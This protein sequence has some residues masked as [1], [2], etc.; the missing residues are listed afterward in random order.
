MMRIR[1][2]TELCSYDTFDDRYEYL[3]LGGSVGADTF[4]FDRWMNQQ[5]YR[6]REW[7]DAR[8][9]V[10]LR[11]EGF[12]LGAVDARRVQRPLVHHMN[13]LTRKD[14]ED[15]SE[16]LLNPEFL[17]TTSP[18]THN[19]IHF[20]DRSLLPQPFVERQPRDTSPWARRD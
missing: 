6:S 5:F 9:F 7:K 15:A 8:E 12:D 20:G 2:Y 13:P 14:I 11:D 19:A 18:L 3:R 4:G 16:N 17:I 1:T 10:V